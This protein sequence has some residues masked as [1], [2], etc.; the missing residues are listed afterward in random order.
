MARKNIESSLEELRLQRNAHIVMDLEDN[1]EA[2]KKLARAKLESLEREFCIQL[3]G[4]L[5]K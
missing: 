4:M 3:L 5:L 1:P 2:E